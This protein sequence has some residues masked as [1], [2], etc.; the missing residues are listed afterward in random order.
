MTSE[1]LDPRLIDTVIRHL[2]PSASTLRLLAVKRQVGAAVA[3]RR[4]DIALIESETA[5]VDAVVLYDAPLTDDD[6][7]HLLTRLRPGGR[8]IAVDPQG[9]ASAA[10]VKRLEM[11]GYTRILVEELPG[12]N[13]GV[14]LRGEKPHT[15]ADTLARIQVVAGLDAS[16]SDGTEFKGRY[17]HLLIRQTP[18]KSIW[19]FKHGESVTW[20]AAAL[21]D[22]DQPLL[23]FSSLPN[24][25]AFMQPAVIAGTIKDVHKIVKYN[26]EAMRNWHLLIN[27]SLE[28]LQ[29]REISFVPIDSFSAEAPDE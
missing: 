20:E 16:A 4:V 1:L 27:P 8:L 6:L 29:G 25:V 19:T 12:A 3:S 9:E 15:T 28:A 24:A 14:L 11:A 5:E 13:V 10:L 17:I 18:N 23:V 26:V 2:P 7:R 22:G 21:A